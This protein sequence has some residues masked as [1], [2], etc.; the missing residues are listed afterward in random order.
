[1]LKIYI[2]LFF[3]VSFNLSAE[4]IQ[5][6]QVN[7]NDRIGKETIEVY[8]GIIIGKDYSSFDVNLLKKLYDT[9]FF[10]NIKISLNNGTLDIIVKEYP[11]INFVTLQGEKSNTVKEKILERLKLREKESFIENKLSEDINLKKSMLL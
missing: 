6:L 5:K 9:N 11:I 7:G 8:G 3:W 4:I 1:M 2:F 10:E